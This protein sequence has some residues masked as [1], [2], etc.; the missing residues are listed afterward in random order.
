MTPLIKTATLCQQSRVLV[1]RST[2]ELT[3]L[4]ERH[5][6]TC[7]HIVT[8][9]TYLQTAGWSPLNQSHEPQAGPAFSLPT[10]RNGDT[11]W[12]K[13]AQETRYFAEKIEDAGLKREMM[14]LAARY[15]K[16]G[17]CGLAT[18]LPVHV[19]SRLGAIAA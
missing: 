10:V 19:P 7:G 4:R 15:E 17:A 18:N 13:R 5:L 2:L 16:L 14:E 1:E 9:R 11:G 6:E 12:N 8:G 3:K